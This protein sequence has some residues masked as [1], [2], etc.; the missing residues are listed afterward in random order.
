MKIAVFTDSNI[1]QQTTVAT[2][3][4]ILKSGLQKLG[5]EVM[6]VTCDLEVDTRYTQGQTV[7]FPSKISNNVYGQ[8][9]K[10]MK[11]F[12][13]TR[14]I[15][16]FAPDVVHIET[17]G[18]MGMA[19]LQY[20]RKRNLPLLATLHSLHDVVSGYEVNPFFDKFIRRRNEYRLKKVLN[21]CD[22]V[23]SASRKNAGI[24]KNLGL[25]FR[26]RIIPFCVDIS[27][28]KPLYSI[29]SGV[30]AIRQDLAIPEGN[31]VIIF[32]GRLNP[33]DN[34]DKLLEDW[35]K[36][37][38][39]NDQLQLLIIGSG[40]EAAALA[41][42]A[43]QL[44]ISD[45]VTFTGEMPRDELTMC[46]AMCKAFVSACTSATLKSSPLEAIAC[47]VP[48]ILK[49]NSANADILINGVNGFTYNQPE[50]LG[51]IIHKLAKIDSDGEV[52][53]KKLVSKT[54]ANLTDINQ[55]QALLSC[56]ELAKEKHEKQKGK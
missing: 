20:A 34:V 30:G 1:N 51:E 31:S 54:A 24:I 45:Q 48:A 49:I 33:D 41:E 53:M 8:S 56:Y 36:A 6:I 11:L 25:K 15:D 40:R 23:T 50:E 7:F 14:L 13:L 10:A 21:H 47:G 2:H 35:S 37:I 12:G 32:S 52:L 17:Y 46:F 28:F 38:D 27:M 5:H 9:A 43:K 16:T 44:G 4:S 26:V 39:E 55:A 19:G 29:D 18:K 22:I 42:K 3:I